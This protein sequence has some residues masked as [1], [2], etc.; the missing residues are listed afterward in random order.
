MMFYVVIIEKETMKDKLIIGLGFKIGVGKD[1]VADF[2]VE[3]YGFTKFKFAGALKEAL[4]I[5]FGWDL[6]DLEDQDFKNTVDPFWE[7]TPRAIMQRF[8]TEIMRDQFRRDIWIKALGHNI[9]RHQCSR[10]VISDV[11][12]I[13]EIDAI[14]KWGGFNVHITRPNW[15]PEHDNKL[16]HVSETELS[17]YDNWDSKI[18]NCGTLKD[19]ENTTAIVVKVL[20]ALKYKL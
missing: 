10:V 14:K 17:E 2:M 11:R 18:N 4:C 6:D 1:A 13:N 16:K 7:M 5:I 20:N 19:L 9:S 15:L 12:F 8:G 3:H